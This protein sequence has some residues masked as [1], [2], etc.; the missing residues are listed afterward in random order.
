MLA[1]AA[2]VLP[3]LAQITALDLDSFALEVTKVIPRSLKL[4][5]GLKYAFSLP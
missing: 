4:P 3:V 5:V 1:A 2:D